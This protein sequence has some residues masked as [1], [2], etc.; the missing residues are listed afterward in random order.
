M[1]KGY[2]QNYTVA[3]YP[4]Q[5]LDSSAGLSTDS[6]PPLTH[7]DLYMKQKVVS[8]QNKCIPMSTIFT[9]S[10]GLEMHSRTESTHTE[11]QSWP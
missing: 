4:Q 1:P 6:Q 5:A 11:E 7:T 3:A 2:Q 9:W 8:P 10:I